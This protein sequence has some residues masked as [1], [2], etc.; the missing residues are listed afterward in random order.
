MF[1]EEPVT[2][3]ID[4]EPGLQT[5]DNVVLTPHL[6]YVTRE[7]YESLFGAA[8]GNLVQAY[9]RGAGRLQPPASPQA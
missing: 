1:D 4:G 6:G 7:G 9:A 8:I 3:P 2:G 5:L